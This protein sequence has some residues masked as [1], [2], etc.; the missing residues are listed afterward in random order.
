MGGQVEVAAHLRALLHGGAILKPGA[1]LQD[2]LW[3][4]VVPQVHGAARNQVRFAWAAVEGELA[5]M[6]D[7]PLVVVEE[8]QLIG[9][10]NFHP[11]LMAHR[12]RCAAPGHRPRGP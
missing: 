5:A 3:L 8:Q 12:L 11:M 7:N 2:P 1:A 4:R 6:D 10:R 9:N